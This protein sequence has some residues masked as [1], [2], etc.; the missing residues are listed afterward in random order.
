MADV[1][2]KSKGP[3]IEYI[4]FE[5]GKPV[6]MVQ[7]APGQ[8]VRRTYYDRYIRKEG[9]TTANGAEE[10]PQDRKR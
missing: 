4:T 8:T 1:E 7:I 5:D 3:I 10:L 9:S 2:E 6:Q